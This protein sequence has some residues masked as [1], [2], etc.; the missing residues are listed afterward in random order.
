MNSRNPNHWDYTCVNKYIPPPKK[1]THTHTH[2]H[3]YTLSHTLYS[4]EGT[5]G[6][7]TVSKLD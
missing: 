2:T 3:V 1:P 7:V 4:F 5:S 6:G